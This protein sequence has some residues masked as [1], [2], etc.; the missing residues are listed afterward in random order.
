[1]SK[2]GNPESNIEALLKAAY[3]VAQAQEK[4]SGEEQTHRDHNREVDHRLRYSIRPLP[5]ADNLRAVKRVVDES[6][7]SYEEWSGAVTRTREW[8]DG[9]RSVTEKRPFKAY[10]F[11]S[12]TSNEGTPQFTFVGSSSIDN[13][14]RSTWELT[15]DASQLPGVEIVEKVGREETARWV[16]TE[17]LAGAEISSDAQQAA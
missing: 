13:H 6:D 12:R 14:L 9:T 16:G 8:E 7:E 4:L 3:E 15:L 2:Q 1:M 5:G 11:S 17:A 10:Y